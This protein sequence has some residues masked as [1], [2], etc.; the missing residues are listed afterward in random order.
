VRLSTADDG[1]L[2]E[3]MRRHS[4]EVQ[5]PPNPGN[6]VLSD[7]T[8]ITLFKPVLITPDFLAPSAVP[9]GTSTLNPE[10]NLAPFR[11]STPLPGCW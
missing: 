6:V 11:A 9:Q 4:D 8:C 2:V 3:L 1:R 5:V 10:A 7:K